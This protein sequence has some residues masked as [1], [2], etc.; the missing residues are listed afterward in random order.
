MAICR[1]LSVSRSGYYQRGVLRGE[2]VPRR[3]AVSDQNLLKEIK[4]IID[5]RPTYGY[6]RIT[7]VL[8]LKYCVNHKRMLRILRENDLTLEKK[9]LRPLRVHNGKV[10]TIKSDV[11]WCS[12]A[13]SIPCDNG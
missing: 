13:T 8:R 4:Q 2:K 1:A 12:D 9:S 10:I 6:R 3:P 5:E 7:A 11:R